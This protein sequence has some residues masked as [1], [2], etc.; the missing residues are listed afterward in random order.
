M[1]ASRVEKN[2]ESGR[3]KEVDR[4][5]NP[6]EGGPS[7]PLKDDEAPPGGGQG[8]GGDKGKPWYKEIFEGIQTVFS[9][10]GTGDGTCA[11]TSACN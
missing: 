4:K 11:E 3:W 5:Y 8:S 6:R 2:G 7:P 1:K 10:P 9:L